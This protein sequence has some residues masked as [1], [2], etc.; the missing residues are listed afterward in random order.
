MTY[1]SFVPLTEGSSIDLDN[2]SLDEGVGT[3]QLVVRGVVNLVIKMTD[4][5]S[6]RQC[7]VQNPMTPNK[8]EQDNKC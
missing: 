1:V 6:V 4:N 5:P 7:L 8:A 3:D 2:S